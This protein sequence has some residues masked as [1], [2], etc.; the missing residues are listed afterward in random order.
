MK[1]ESTKYEG[2]LPGSVLTI[3]KIQIKVNKNKVPAAIVLASSVKYGYFWVTRQRLN[4]QIV[5]QKE[6]IRNSKS[7]A[8]KWWKKW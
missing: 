2:T 1:V 4:L 7:V 5:N 3:L 6:G 8:G